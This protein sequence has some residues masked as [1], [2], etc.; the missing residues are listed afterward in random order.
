MHCGVLGCR[1]VCAHRGADI[2]RERQ[3][4]AQQMVS[5]D[6]WD[7]LLRHDAVIYFGLDKK[8]GLDF[9]SNRGGLCI[10]VSDWALGDAIAQAKKIEVRRATDATSTGEKT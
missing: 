7:W 8:I 2:Q 10:Q 5:Q 9:R 4:R 1:G 3:E 6:D